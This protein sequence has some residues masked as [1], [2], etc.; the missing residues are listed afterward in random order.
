MIA[1]SGVYRCSSSLRLMD[2]IYL[3]YCVDSRCR[4][5]E[6]GT[7]SYGS[8]LRPKKIKNTGMLNHLMPK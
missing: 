1:I 6:N 3:D 5:G 8:K 4:D 2:T 7:N